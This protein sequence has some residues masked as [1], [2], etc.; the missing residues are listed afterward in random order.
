MGAAM[1]AALVVLAVASALTEPV[2]VEGLSVSD[3]IVEVHEK[4]KHLDAL[5]SDKEW[6]EWSPASYDMW[7]AI[8]KYVASLAPQDSQ[9]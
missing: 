8:R 3:P 6:L 9:D 5:F 4:Y 2:E 1:S 7:Q